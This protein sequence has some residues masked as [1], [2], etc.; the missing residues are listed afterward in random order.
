MHRILSCL[1]FIIG[2]SPLWATEPITIREPSFSFLEYARSNGPMLKEL[3]GL[4][5]EQCVQRLPKMLQD[6]EDLQTKYDKA[7][8]SYQTTRHF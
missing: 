4:S 1:I 7:I 5:K 8:D 6:L 2:S 3:T